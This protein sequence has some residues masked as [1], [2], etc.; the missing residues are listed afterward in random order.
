MDRALD[1]VESCAGST[2]RRVG[3]RK[4]KWISELDAHL[5]REV[6]LHKPHGQ[7]HGRIGN[8]YES[9]A[10]SLNESERLPW[11]TERKHLQGR[12]QHLL[13]AR[14]TNQRATAKATGIEEEHGELEILLDYVIEEADA[15]KS[16]EVEGREVRRH[17]DV[18]ML[19]W[20]KE[21][22]KRG[23]LRWR[24][25]HPWMKATREVQ[26]V[27]DDSDGGSGT[28]EPQEVARE[29]QSSTPVSVAHRNVPPQENEEAQIMQLLQKS[30]SAISSQASRVAEV[31]ERKLRLEE[32]RIEREGEIE[33]RRIKVE[34]DREARLQRNED[35]QAQMEE[36][37]IASQKAQT[38]LMLKML[39]IVQKKLP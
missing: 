18:A 38:E 37:R 16:T 36:L 12:V 14:R 25:R 22:G 7:R 24:D 2:A 31:D 35:R 15:L 33:K 6:K 8:V 3:T 10:A 9:L 1:D 29:C 4:R 20:R 28:D 5:P 30:A 32:G 17:R 19:Q 13:E 21:V 39:E 27:E 11:I 26:S 34:E 23:G